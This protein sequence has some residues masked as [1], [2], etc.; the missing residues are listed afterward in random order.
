MQQRQKWTALRRNL[1][2]GDVVLVTDATA[3]RGS[4]MMGKV[5]DVRSDVNGVVRSVRLQMKTSILDRPVTKLCL[6]LEAAV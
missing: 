6:L 2:P 5:L 4:W 1:T 3:S